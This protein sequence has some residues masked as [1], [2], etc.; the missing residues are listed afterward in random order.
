MQYKRDFSSLAALVIARAARLVAV[1][2]RMGKVARDS[3][4]RAL[5]TIKMV[6]SNPPLDASS[7]AA[8]ACRSPTPS[9]ME[10]MVDR[11]QLEA[12][13]EAVKILKA[14]KGVSRGKGSGIITN[15]K[16]PTAAALVMARAASRL[17]A[18]HG[19]LALARVAKALN[20]EALDALRKRHSVL[21]GPT[22]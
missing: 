3:E 4:R 20:K 10:A 21:G 19:D 9:E 6:R 7:S 11:D 5:G 17:A 13:Q 1:N 18:K 8:R 2:S 15:Q 12:M 22:T 16:F 14:R